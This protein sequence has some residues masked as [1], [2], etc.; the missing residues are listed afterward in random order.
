MVKNICAPDYSE[1]YLVCPV[2]KGEFVK[3]DERYACFS[4]GDFC[5]NDRIANFAAE[6]VLQF[7]KDKIVN[8]FDSHAKY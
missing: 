5:Q 2:C 8:V 4:P 6:S 7:D 3:H 1:K